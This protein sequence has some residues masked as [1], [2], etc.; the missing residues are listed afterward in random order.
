M[1]QTSSVSAFVAHKNIVKSSLSSNEQLQIGEI[2]V[3]KDSKYSTKHYVQI[4]RF[5]QRSQKKTKTLEVEGIEL[6]NRGQSKGIYYFE[7]CSSRLANAPDCY[8]RGRIVNYNPSEVEGLIEIIQNHSSTCKFIAVHETIGEQGIQT[9]E[10][11][12]QMYKTMKIEIIKKLEE[13]DWLTPGEILDW[14]KK[15]FPV[16]MHLS[17][18]RVNDIVQYWRKTNNVTKESYALSHTQNKTGLPF[19]RAFL[20]INYKKVNS[21]KQIKIAIWSSDFQLN[22]LRLTNH[23][24]IDGT[25]TIVPSTYSQLMTFLIRDPN[26]GYLKPALWALVNSKEEE[27]YFQLFQTIKN[28]VSSSETL[29]WSLS[30]ATLD[31]EKGL[32]NAFGR[33]FSSTRIVGCLFH[34]KQ[35]LYREAQ[36]LGLLKEELKEGAQN[37]I[38][39][40][41]SLS[42]SN[43]LNLV[44]T[45]FEEIK[46]QYVDTQYLKLIDYYQNNWLDRLKSGLIDYSSVDDEIRSNSVL[47]QYNAH[48]KNILPRSPSWAKFIEFLVNEEAKYIEESFANEVRGQVATWKNLSSKGDKTKKIEP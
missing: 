2:E 18:N 41:S 23:W 8:F 15:N 4:I 32:I 31:F 19:L 39:L 30:S 36:N 6:H 14:I 38:R 47:E 10:A 12:K 37:V 26:T 3:K 16:N 33:V 24:F 13:Q 20:V 1:K 17:Y 11:N 43:A 27:C 25:F 29:S 22:R 9:F 35:A 5:D 40:L 48:I 7:C 46:S 44:E 42:W 28:I 34:F 21:D 45:E